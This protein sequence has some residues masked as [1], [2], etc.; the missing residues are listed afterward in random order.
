MKSRHQTVDNINGLCIQC[1]AGADAYQHY[2]YEGNISGNHYNC[3]C[4]VIPAWRNSDSILGSRP[5][6]SIKSSIGSRL[7]PCSRIACMNS[8]P[9]SRSKIPFSSNLEKASDDKISAHL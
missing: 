2:S 3:S 5:R 9:V 7:P 4:V 8:C 1:G 6:N